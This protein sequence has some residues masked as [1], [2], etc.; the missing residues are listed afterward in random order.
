VN[1]FDDVLGGLFD[2]K[3]TTTQVVTEKWLVFGNGS[4]VRVSAIDYLKK[5]EQG[6][7][8]YLRSGESLTVKIAPE[9][10]WDNI[11]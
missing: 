8:I 11:K 1:A 2:Y 6:T 10:L 5:V 7:T 4:R 3:S 9:A